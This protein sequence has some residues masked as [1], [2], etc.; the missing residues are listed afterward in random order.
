MNIDDTKYGEET[1]IVCMIKDVKH[2]PFHCHKSVQS[3][4]VIVSSAFKTL[5]MGLVLDNIVHLASTMFISFIP[6]IKQ[7]LT[8][9][10]WY[11]CEPWHV[12]TSSYMQSSYYTIVIV[13]PQ[14]NKFNMFCFAISYIL[15]ADW[16]FCSFSQ[17]WRH[18][19]SLQRS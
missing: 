17:F 2:H 18:S 14:R 9:Y 13:G 11:I 8:K 1:G 12:S 4:K 5:W 7:F 16:F 6:T 10:I 19:W 3:I 15:V